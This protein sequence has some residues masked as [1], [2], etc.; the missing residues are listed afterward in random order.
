MQSLG[1]LFLC[2]LVWFRKTD[3]IVPS[4]DSNVFE[5]SVSEKDSTDCQSTTSMPLMVW[6]EMGFQ[7]DD[8]LYRLLGIA[9]REVFL[10]RKEGKGAR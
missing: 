10:Y 2:R 3:W 9:Q 6:K 5:T 1:G 4:S 7:K 8:V